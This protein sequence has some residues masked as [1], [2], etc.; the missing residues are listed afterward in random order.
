MPDP[1]SNPVRLQQLI[2]LALQQ[3]EAE[4][5]AY[6]QKVAAHDPALREAALAQIAHHSKPVDK[7]RFFSRDHGAASSTDDALPSELQSL[8]AG[9][10]IGDFTLVR[11][12]GKGG[13][14]QVW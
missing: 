14:G 4:R 7:R 8:R 1:A 11:F 5:V 10:R 2:D 6:V 3:P 13:M 9:Q 12:L